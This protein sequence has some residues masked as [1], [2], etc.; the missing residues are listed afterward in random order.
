M[1][2]RALGGIKIVCPIPKVGCTSG[3]GGIVPTGNTC[4][5]VPS[6]NTHAFLGT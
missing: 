2:I 4:G 3:I 1:R 6:G 5:I